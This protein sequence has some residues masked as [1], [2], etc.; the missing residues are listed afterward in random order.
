MTTTPN[1]PDGSLR[2]GTLRP[3]RTSTPGEGVRTKPLA[4][5]ILACAS[6][7]VA[8][9]MVSPA[10]PGPWYEELVRPTPVIPDLVYAVLVAA[11]YVAFAVLLYRAQVHL[12]DPARRVVLALTVGVM[13]VQSAWSP[14][15]VRVQ[16]LDAGVAMAGVVAGGMVALLFILLPRDR[17][18]ALVLAPY[19]ALALHDF[20]WARA[21][22]RL[23]AG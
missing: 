6:V 22:M 1:P 20:W 13:L 11:F 23:N 4:V 18:A 2:P 14:V 8:T 12:R 15:L 16:S 3:A 17:V 19:A 10:A 5:A 7:A 21:L 9:V